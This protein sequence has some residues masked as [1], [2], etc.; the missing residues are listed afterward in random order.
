MRFS[1]ILATF[2]AAAA[3]LASSCSDRVPP[4]A[5]PTP[6]PLSMDD[7]AERVCALA[8]EVADTLDVPDRESQGT[9]AERKQWVAGTVAPRA[10]ALALIEEDIAALQ[11]PPEVAEFSGSFIDYHA[12]FQLTVNRIVRAWRELVDTA[13]EAQSTEEIEAASIAFFRAKRE[14]IA[15]MMTFDN[16]WLVSGEMKDALSQPRDCGFLH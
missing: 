9:L 11:P 8:V 2:V 7:W 10:E 16:A 4:S 13:E 6:T 1:L 5:T 12:D 14:A 3:L 15:R